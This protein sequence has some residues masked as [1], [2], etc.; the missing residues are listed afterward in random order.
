MASNTRVFNVTRR[1]YMKHKQAVLG[2]GNCAFAWV[3]FGV[4]VRD[5]TPA[6]SVTAR[7]HRVSN[8]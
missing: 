2:V 1:F 5:L 6:E 8:V 7:K 3:E 4:T